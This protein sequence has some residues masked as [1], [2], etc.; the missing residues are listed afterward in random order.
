MAFPKESVSA[1]HEPHARR[2]EPQLDDRDGEQRSRVDREGP[3]GDKRASRC[4][5]Y[6]LYAF[7]S[8]TSDQRHQQSRRK[9]WPGVQPVSTT[10]ENTV[11]LEIRKFCHVTTAEFEH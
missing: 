11:V 9:I 2:K 1:H 6:H 4:R 3:L 10:V 7:V 5:A 8:A